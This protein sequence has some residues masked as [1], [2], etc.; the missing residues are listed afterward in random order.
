MRSTRSWTML[1][2]S[3]RVL[4]TP[5]RKILMV[6]RLLDRQTSL[7]K[8]LTSGSAILGDKG[9][10][11]LDQS[12]P[13]FDHDMLRLEAR[14]SFRKR[15]EKIIAVFPR[16]FELL[17]ADEV[18]LVERF[19]ETCPPADVS[20]LANARQ[21][22]DFLCDHWRREPP[23]PPYLRDVVAC[24][25]AQAEVRIELEQREPEASSRRTGALRRIRRRRGIVL[26]RCAYDVRSVFECDTGKAAPIERDTPIAVAMPA[27]ADQPQVSEVPPVIFD[28]LVALDNWTDAA[29][30]GETPELKDIIEELAEHGLIEGRR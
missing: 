10:T 24:E 2:A 27:D 8:Y 26:L 11:S 29:D 22:H 30:L 1:R 20:R 15:M 18:P 6:N 14:F 25:L 16:T 19:A 17:G 23:E 4:P 7:L 21:F 12:L 5:D 13:G 3:A 9:D 28:M